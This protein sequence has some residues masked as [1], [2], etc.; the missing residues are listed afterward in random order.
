MTAQQS[1]Q[2]VKRSVILTREL[3]AWIEAQAKAGDLSDSQ[4]IRRILLAAMAADRLADQ[5]KRRAS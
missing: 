4:V 2:K 3:L 1:P 5:Q